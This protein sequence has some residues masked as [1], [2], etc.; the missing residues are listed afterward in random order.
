MN[1]SERSI[2]WDKSEKHSGGIITGYLT[3]N[4][5]EQNKTANVDIESYLFAI[6]HYSVTR[7]RGVYAEEGHD[8]SLE[9]SFLV[10]NRGVEGD[11]GGELERDLFALGE[12]Y[13][14]E[15]VVIIPVG[16]KNAYLLYCRDV[17]ER[18]IK[19]GDKEFIGGAKFVDFKS[20]AFSR[21][22]GRAWAYELEENQLPERYAEIALDNKSIYY[23]GKDVER[24][25]IAEG[26]LPKPEFK[27]AC[28]YFSESKPG[29]F[30]DLGKGK[31]KCVEA[32]DSDID[33]NVK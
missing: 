20:P 2:I 23:R 14:Q 18:D 16:G 13:G 12:K 15:S 32:E 5:R 19:K 9:T 25:L 29:D 8:E 17:P 6:R 26:F 21:V 28:G 33:K 30:S 4:T 24:A 7:I 31:I 11:D 3:G 27:P 1:N 10:H 22:G